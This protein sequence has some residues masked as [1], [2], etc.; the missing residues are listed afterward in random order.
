MVRF[1]RKLSTFFQSATGM[2]VA[3]GGLIAAISALEASFH[4]LGCRHVIE[5]SPTPTPSISFS[6]TAVST[7]R[8]KPT[9]TITQ[10][11]SQSP[12]P[13]TYST[14]TPSLVAT[15]APGETPD[16][17][18]A[19]LEHH[20]FAGDV[21]HL[22]TQDD[23]GAIFDQSIGIKSGVTLTSGSGTISARIISLRYTPGPNREQLVLSGDGK[24][25]KGETLRAGKWH[26]ATWR[27]LGPSCPAPKP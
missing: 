11:A 21:C 6:P 23:T 13:S 3:I 1:L 22:L 10:T 4:A 19:W 12:V 16:A 18:G 26:K 15:P 17:H 2:V 20:V 25:L 5:S 9:L 7:V 8:I 14:V 27:Y 24:E